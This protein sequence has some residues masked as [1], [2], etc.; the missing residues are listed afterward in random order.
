MRAQRV[1]TRVGACAEICAFL[2]IM[3]NEIWKDVQNFEGLYQVSNLGRV[4]SLDRKKWGGKVFYTLK[5]RILKP[6]LDGKG[7]YLQICFHKDG[8]TYHKQIH[9]LVAG[10]FLKNPN[11]YP[12]INHKNEIKT[13]NRAENLEWC[14]YSYN[15]LYGNAR[16]KNVISRTKNKSKNSEKP[17]L[18]IDLNGNV[19]REFR[20]CYDA[21]RFTGLSR[22]IIRYCCI[23]NKRNKTAG[24]Y[25]WKYKESYESNIL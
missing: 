22:T 14:S 11:N 23:G 8:K 13:D 16:F 5:G 20:S 17:I 4:R 19:I 1:S 10:E 21:S 12:C 3:E 18:M 25:K 7:N 6:K 2:F 9:Q 24:G 15:A